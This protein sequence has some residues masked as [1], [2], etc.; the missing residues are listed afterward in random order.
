MVQQITN[1]ARQA[2]KR[3]MKT[4]GMKSGKQYRKWVKKERRNNKEGKP[5]D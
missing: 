2:K 1:P 3:T 4:W 5:I